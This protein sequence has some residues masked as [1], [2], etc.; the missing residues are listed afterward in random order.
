VHM[1]VD[2]TTVALYSIAVMFFVGFLMLFLIYYFTSPLYTVYGDK[3]SRLYYSL[4]NSFYFS[5]L[6]TLLFSVLT[7]FMDRIGM[8]ATLAICAIA[9]L[10][11]TALQVYIIAELVKRNIIVMRQK[12]RTAKNK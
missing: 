1:L 10:A 9:M 7:M 11:G 12:R 4:F 5:L 6:L 3:R 8:I 2:N